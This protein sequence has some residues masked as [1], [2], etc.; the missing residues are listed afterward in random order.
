MLTIHCSNCGKSYRVQDELLGKRLQCGGCGGEISS[1]LAAV[2]SPPSP[3]NPIESPPAAGHGPSMA[4]GGSAP[5][6]GYSHVPAYGPQGGAG[7]PP[8]MNPAAEWG[9]GQAGYGFAPVKPPVR[10]GRGQIGLLIAAP[11]VLIAVAIAVMIH[12]GVFPGSGPAMAAAN[13]LPSDPEIAVQLVETHKFDKFSI[14]TPAGYS[15]EKLELGM[16][17]PPSSS[18]WLCKDLHPNSRVVGSIAIAFVPAPLNSGPK[19][20][21]EFRSYSNLLLS[22]EVGNFPNGFRGQYLGRVEIGGM[23]FA[24]MNFETEVEGNVVYGDV[25][26]NC[27]GDR[28]LTITCT[29]PRLSSGPADKIQREIIV[30]LRP[31]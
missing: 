24:M 30:S 23:E 25:F 19:T 14:R 27:F 12:F 31:E 6:A 15:V 1:M 29:R 4:M 2:D 10:L 18:I 9:G 11:I 8:G 20:D 22:E 13:K 21:E 28:K 3:W 26:S 17:A 5:F 16:G 7:A